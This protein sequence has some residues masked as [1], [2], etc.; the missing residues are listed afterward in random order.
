MTSLLGVAFNDSVGV[1]FRELVGVVFG[2]LACFLLL[3]AP[4]PVDSFVDD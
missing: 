2:E 3:L 4:P 1:D